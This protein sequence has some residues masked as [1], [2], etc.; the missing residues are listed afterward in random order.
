MRIFSSCSIL[1]LLSVLF[2]AQLA[3]QPQVSYIIPDI[4]AP[5]M[6]TYVE[7]IAPQGAAAPFGTDGIYL[8]NPG[9]NL[10]VIASGAAAADVVIGPFVVSWNGRLISTQVFVKPGVA[11]NR[12]VQ[13]IVQNGAG[14]SAP[15]DFD[16]IAPAALSSGA[17][18][19]LGQ[20]GL[21]QRSKRGAMIVSSLSLT[22]GSYTVSTNDPDN[23]AAGNQGFLP[24]I[25]ISRGP[26]TIGSGVTITA[27]AG[28]RDGGPGGGGGG[29]QVCDAF[30]S[31]GSTGTSGGNGFTGGGGGGRNGGGQAD[32]D[33][34]N[35]SGA[36]GKSLNEVPAALGSAECADP[37]GAGGGTGHPFGQ[38]GDN[39]CQGFSGKYGGGGSGHQDGGLTGIGSGGGGGAYGADGSNGTGNTTSDTRGK[40]HGNV[41][42][43]PLA[44]G[45]GGAAGNPRG[46]GVC[47][48]T[49]GGGGG[50]IALYSLGRMTMGGTVSANGAAGGAPGGGQ[51]GG[52]GGSGGGII[53]GAKDPASTGGGSHTASAGNGGSN[54]GGAGSVGRTRYDG[55]VAGAPAFSPGNGYVGPTTDTTSYVTSS[56]FTLTGTRGGTSGIRVYMRGDNTGWQQL[57]V[58]NY[59]G[60]NWSLDV[61]TA[62]SGNFYFAAF[63]EV[64]N[65]N[66]GQYTAE[67]GW[68]TSQVAGNV[69]KVAAVPRIDTIGSPL[70]S[71]GIT[72]GCPGDSL[73]YPVLRF[74]SAG[75]QPLQV[76]VELLGADRNQFEVVSPA[77]ITT[78][79][80]Q[81]FPPGPDEIVIQLRFKPTS[82]GQKN[83]SIRLITND[84]R[85]GFDTL[86]PIDVSATHPRVEVSLSRDTLD[87][88]QVCLNTA[89]IDSV[90]VRYIGENRSS[91]SSI[92]GLKPNSPF[93]LVR[94]TVFPAN[95]RQPLP[96]EIVEDSIPVV[97]RFRPR[98]TGPFTDSLVI[99]DDC[100]KHILYLRGEGFEAQLVAPAAVN[101]GQI[102]I[103]TTSDETIVIRNTGG[104]PVT[105][106]TG[107]I[108]PA[109]S[110][111]TIIDPPSLD[112]ITINANDSVVITV[113]FSPD[114]IGPFFGKLEFDVEGPCNTLNGINLNGLG[115]DVCIRS[116][117]MGFA[118]NAD[119][120]SVNPQPIDTTVTLEN[121]GGIDVEI[122]ETFAVNSKVSLTL[123][124]PLPHTL[125]SV[126]STNIRGTITW[127]PLNAGTGTDSVAVVWRDTKR[128]TVDTLWIPI[129][130]KFDRAIVQLQTVTGDTVPS[131]LD[132]GGVYQCSPARDTV[133]LVNAGT[134]EGEITGGFQN[135]GLFE[136]DPPLP[137]H[138]A[139]GE[140]K[141]LVISLDPSRAADVG[142]TYQ[143]EL[144]LRNGKCDQEWKIG[145]T[146]TRYNLTFDV[147]NVN[148]GGTNL[149]LPRS[150]TVRFT[151][152]TNAPPIEEL[153]IGSV[154]IDP[155]S[156]SPPFAITDPTLVPARVQADSGRLDLEV[157]FTPDQEQVYN[158]QLCF[159]I[160]EPC[161]TIICVDMDGE[162]IRSNIYVPKGDLNF[163]DVYFCSDSTMMVT[164][165]SVGPEPL[166]VDS[167]RIV[168]P[169]QAG[170]EI[171]S[172]SRNLP[173]VLDPGFPTIVDFIDVVIRFNPAAVPPDGP[174]T[175]SLE[176]YSND[177]AQ[178]LLTVPLIG[179]RVSPAIVGPAL[180][181]YGTVV[182][183]AVGTIG[184]TLTN[185]SRDT[186]RI[187][188]PRVGAPFRIVSPLPLVIPPGETITVNVEFKPDDSRIYNDTLVGLF[189]LPC[190]G[191]VRVPL[192]GEGLRGNTIISIPT[193][194]TGE[195]RQRVSIP[196]VLEEAESIAQVGATTFR[197]WIRF[198][199]S[200][201]LPVDVQF[202]GAAGKRTAASG[203]ILSDVI[204]G[205]D[206]VL[207]VEITNNPLPAAPDTLG[208]IDAVVLLGNSVT[209]PITFDSLR[210][211]DGEV[212]TTTRDG[213]F[214]L[215][216]YCQVGTDRLVRVEG[217]FGIKAVTPN[218]LESAAEIEFE[219]VE[220]GRTVLEVY[221]VYG[222]KVITL[223]DADD[224]PV[225]G[226]L[227]TWSA[228]DEA[229]GIYFA[230]LSTPTQRSVRRMVLVK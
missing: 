22:G 230:V 23:G 49:G 207:E 193:V 43:V 40:E 67:P 185:T 7:I 198:N 171:L 130:L 84:P 5:G 187:T 117:P 209:T 100:G 183:N 15:V 190:D 10:R 24:F 186:I 211:V 63:Q 191:E 150:Q 137:F 97:V 65:P 2:A 101:F 222:R 194:L 11:A 210:W 148:F 25:L 20:G 112:G 53:L 177:S 3:A 145:V 111:Y 74:K 96:P 141:I 41:H 19:V 179:N 138:L 82:S 208:W 46:L 57:G 4:G 225:Q 8:N 175:A 217:A 9:D 206:R 35:G 136:V 164:I 196:I 170:F 120:C 114:S 30:G 37:E 52:G 223:V 13:L 33:A 83:V 91:I 160:I 135:G 161:D 202:D 6:N 221:D 102:A 166:R 144:V 173:D 227:V 172:I 154:Y 61:S 48:G 72:G 42:I 56:N 79:P 116:A 89:V 60:R 62:G 129:T 103:G 95:F 123:P 201:L 12:T 113:R 80:G 69:V 204:D 169:D 134:V 184:V 149:G 110:G 76:L 140:S 119:S 99:E 29:G 220:N 228:G 162:G 85:K 70:L 14:Q 139:V 219:T 38:G 118:F 213:E 159:H 218:P 178:G 106:R 188:N 163:G 203:S 215:D 34:G 152:T 73:T 21:G 39:A 66:N 158:G 64:T 55:F 214:T 50:A 146:S 126:S 195:P 36:V 168:G 142:T 181:D 176:I 98:A 121:C 59:S 104:N 107:S 157:T 47:A 109:N 81:I 51:R 180:V 87:F 199:A 108:T 1:L 16:I 115:V 32:H 197:A 27:N 153:V 88:G 17:G 105:I 205:T 28:G 93:S 143:D 71:F 124:L 75:S 155:P 125:G 151:N 128:G 54:G 216:G 224:L 182:V 18:G 94:P 31:G 192:T 132:I 86:G 78:P 68:V 167:I 90:L 44:G 127:D 226:H 77:G 58:P 122:L 189:T 200:M 212:A 156:A 147:G 229:A 45:S 165:F 92:L 174:K 131:L 26:V 133:V